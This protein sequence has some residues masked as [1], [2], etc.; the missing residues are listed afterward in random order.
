MKLSEFKKDAHDFSSKLSDINRNLSFAGIAIIWIFRLESKNGLI[1][2]ECLYLPLFFLVGSLA[3]DL[4]QYLYSTTVW[5][6]FYRIKEGKK[7]NIKDDPVTTAPKVLSNISY[8]CFY[9]PKVIVNIVAYIFLF[10]YLSKV[11]F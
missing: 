3:L 11:A 9:Y 10:L 2:P 8:F 5:T 7:S 6:I 4:L 1:L